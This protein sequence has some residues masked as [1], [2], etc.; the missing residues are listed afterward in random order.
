M[1]TMLAMLAMVACA[2]PKKT[3]PIFEEDASANVVDADVTVDAVADVAQGPYAPPRS[4][5]S[6]M[7]L[8][9]GWRF[10]RMDVAGAE[11][12]AFDDG[13][14]AAVALPHTWNNLDGEDGGNNYFRGIG[15]Y[16]RHLMV[17]AEL[18]GRALY[19]QFD[20]ASIA[21]DVFVNGQHVGQH[22]GAFSAFRF[23]VTAAVKVGQD[24]V[25]AVKVSNAYDNDVPTLGGDFNLDGGLYRS[26][27]LLA[28][29]PVHVDVEDFAGPGA[30]L[31][32]SHVSADAAD[33]S[34]LIKLKNGDTR[35]HAVH[36]SLTLVE[37][38]GT[39]FQQL[40]ADRLLSPGADSVTLAATVRAPHLWNARLDPFVYTAYVEVA[41]A[42]VVR[43]L[44]AEPLGFRS[45]S[46]DAESGFS[47]NGRP[48]DLHGANRHQDWWQKGW[49][50][51]QAEQ[52]TDMALLM[53]MGATVVRLCHY[54]HARAFHALADRNGMI[55]WSELGLVNGITASP[56]FT[57][58]A[59]QQLTELI[60]QNFNHPSIVFWSLSNELS[61][62]P[63]Y[64]PLQM[65]LNALAHAE[66]PG[67]LTTLATN[68]PDGAPITAIPDVIAHNKYFGWY[69]GTYDQIG[70]W[71]DHVHQTLPALKIGISEYGA[72]SSVNIHSAAPV[73]ADY[74][75]EYQALFHEA[76]WK[77]L[78]PRKFLW[79]K[80][81]WQM[82]DTA[83]DG[84]HEAD[85]I[86][87]NNK[88]MVTADRQIRK[89]AFY[90]YKANWTTTPFVYITSRRFVRRPVATADLK[91]YANTASVE[92]LLDGKSLGSKTSA[93]HIFLWPAV[94]LAL[95]DHTVEARG[96]GGERD[97]IT[98]TRIVPPDAGV[99]DAGADAGARDAARDTLAR[100]VRGGG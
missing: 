1:M 20:A 22:K 6:V 87:R 89:D 11:A 24:N 48:Y 75:E 86:G 56:A 12:A 91:V 19:L 53:E 92:L 76:Y 7:D 33:L 73:P 61:S 58:S 81:I 54:Q 37:P 62:G 93:D 64:V 80:F 36:V 16:R 5:R 99:P 28:V 40:G 4:N 94:P 18:A 57:A 67:R 84:R 59:R 30:Y 70:P 60:R 69:G 51:G 97:E 100:D 78:A 65:E 8:D 2:R 90:W 72:G 34:A 29:D 74:S 25:I 17:P 98:F 96:P 35:A 38:D 63:D 32:T 21:A 10:V 82:F 79:G 31:R 45:F 43:D 26:A 15:W 27:Q 85:Q 41:E 3:A 66:D 42:G 55:V 44:V 71:A 23:D 50:I 9:P 83:S 77:A 46:V 39:I 52:E 68:N 14:W 88:G 49:A 13:A 95:G 47:L